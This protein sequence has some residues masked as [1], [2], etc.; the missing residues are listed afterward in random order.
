M[1]VTFTDVWHSHVVT[2]IKS[3][4]KNVIKENYH[5]S[6]FLSYLLVGL[7]KFSNIFVERIY[8]QKNFDMNFKG[9]H[10]GCVRL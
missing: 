7:T 8:Q 3:A 6:K 1:F 9:C 2:Y 5:S 4:I 10:L